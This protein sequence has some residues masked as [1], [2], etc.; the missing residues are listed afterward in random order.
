[1]ATFE[2]KQWYRARYYTYDR[3]RTDMIYE[4]KSV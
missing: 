4:E 1:M 3:L 2:K